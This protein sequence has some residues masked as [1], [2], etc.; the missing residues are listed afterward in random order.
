MRKLSATMSWREEHS[1]NVG[2]AIAEI[3]SFPVL[4]IYNLLACS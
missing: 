1:V 3:D 4:G 2:I